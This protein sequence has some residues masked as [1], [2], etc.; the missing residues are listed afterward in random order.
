MRTWPIGTKVY[1]VAN[2]NGHDYTIGRAYA[3]AEVD[4]DGTLRAR[5]LDTGITGNWL[6]WQD[7]DVT[8]PIG[9]DFCKKVL[10]PEVVQF[11][12][13]FAGIE[14]ILLRG[15]VQLRLLQRTPD[16]YGSILA[17]AGKMA[18]EQPE[19]V[20]QPRAPRSRRRP[21]PSS[22]LEMLKMLGALEDDTDPELMS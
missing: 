11:L 6:R 18:E 19:T 15:D 16:L 14:S 7:V 5:D 2:A 20:P 21:R 4:E 3:V 9:W 12:S 8:P 13:A 10:P 17:E 22:P 1:I